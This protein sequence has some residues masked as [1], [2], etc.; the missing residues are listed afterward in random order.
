M[1]SSRQKRRGI[2]RWGQI[3]ER[4]VRAERM[5]EGEVCNF[6]FDATLIL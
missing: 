1:T 4:P 6:D 5:A 2:Q 3:K